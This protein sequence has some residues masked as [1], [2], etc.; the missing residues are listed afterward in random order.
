MEHLRNFFD[1]APLIF[2]IFDD[3]FNL[4]DINKYTLSMFRG[5]SKEELIGKHITEI[6][7]DVE[8]SGRLEHYKEVLQTGIP[9]ETRHFQPH[10]I[11]GIGTGSVKVFKMGECVGMIGLD[12][13]EW[14]KAE[15][16]LKNALEEK[17]SLVNKLKSFSYSVSHDLKAPLRSIIGY[18]RILEEDYSAGLDEEGKGVTRRIAKSAEKMRKLIDDILIFSQLSSQKI[19]VEEINMEELFDIVYRELTESIEDRDIKFRLGTLKSIK[20]D[21]NLIVQLLVN[22]LSNAIK[23]TR[24]RNKAV[25]E[26]DGREMEEGYVYS[27]KDNGVGFDMKFYDRIFGE[28]QRLHSQSEFEGTGVGLAIALHVVN[29]HNGRIWAE[30]ELDKGSIFYFSIPGR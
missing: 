9:F 26:V 2:C 20:G 16:D 10:A 24:P 22:L 14:Q 13:T 27:I 1:T 11:Y 15:D 28:F 12:V 7:S 6:S 19:V 8:K 5:R 29:H 4:I 23:Y 3:Q 30:S 18:S 17:A 25:I 21:K